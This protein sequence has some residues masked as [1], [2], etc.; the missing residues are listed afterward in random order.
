MWTFRQYKYV[1][2]KNFQ[3]KIF[4]FCP[5]GDRSALTHS[6]KLLYSVRK[7]PTVPDTFR[8]LSRFFEISRYPVEP[9]KAPH[10]F[11]LDRITLFCRKC[12][13]GKVSIA[14][15]C[16]QG[17]KG[18]DFRRKYYPSLDGMRGHI[19]ASRGRK[20]FSSVPPATP[21]EGES[22][23]RDGVPAGGGLGAKPLRSFFVKNTF[24]Q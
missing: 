11:P 6:K 20:R 16:S 12:N 3:E 13:Q 8:V 14:R 18:G 23:C 1:I 19:L 15:K 22:G 21:G 24:L 5:I 7:F 2:W 4:F 9:V 10:G 17:F